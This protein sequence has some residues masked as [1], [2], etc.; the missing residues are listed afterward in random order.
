MIS[1]D[2]TRFD[3][4]QRLAA[5]ETLAHPPF[6]FMHIITRLAE[7]ERQV[8]ALAPELPPPDPVA[9]IIGQPAHKRIGF[10]DAYASECSLQQVT[11]GGKPALWLGVNNH[12]MLLTD[13]LAAWLLQPLSHFAEHG[14]LPGGGA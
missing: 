7:L 14:T 5:L 8:R 13:Q 1:V 4:E 11:I 6:D 12:R 10:M 2:K 3:P 9:F